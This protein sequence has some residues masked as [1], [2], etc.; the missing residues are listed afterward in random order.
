VE[1][2]VG[3]VFTSNRRKWAD[4][5]SLLKEERYA[6]VEHTSNIYTTLLPHFELTTSRNHETT[7]DFSMLDL[8]NAM[9]HQLPTG[10][11]RCFD[12]IITTNCWLS[13][14]MY[15]CIQHEPTRLRREYVSRNRRLGAMLAGVFQ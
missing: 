14:A 2:A 4:R 1:Q 15:R 7:L 8:L 5:A 13:S 3:K 6:G 11:R 9:P 12:A 10:S